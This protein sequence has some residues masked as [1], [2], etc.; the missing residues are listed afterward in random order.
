MTKSTQMSVTTFISKGAYEM[1]EEIVVQPSVEKIDGYKC[2]SCDMLYDDDSANFEPLYECQNC[3]TRFIR[4]N[5]M[6]GDNHQCPDC[7]KFA[8]KLSD[9]GCEDCGEGDCEETELW[10]C[11]E[12][13]ELFETEEEAK[14]HHLAE[15]T[16]DYTEDDMPDEEEECHGD[17]D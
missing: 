3:G 14:S 10:R 8:S 17:L 9:N 6:T 2:D 1:T 5:S 15:H 12:C 4:S 13:S 16:R 11:N 7:A